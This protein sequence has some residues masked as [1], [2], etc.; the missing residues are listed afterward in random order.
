MNYIA[1]GTNSWL[2]IILTIITNPLLSFASENSTTTTVKPARGPTE[3]TSDVVSDDD[4]S[5]DSETNARHTAIVY[6]C[7]FSLLL[8]HMACVIIACMLCFRH[9]INNSGWFGNRNGTRDEEN[10]TG[11][12]AA[13]RDS[14]DEYLVFTKSV[15]KDLFLSFDSPKTSPY[16][17]EF[18]H[19]EHQSRQPIKVPF[20]GYDLPKFVETTGAKDSD[21]RISTCEDSRVTIN[22]SGI[23][24]SG[25]DNPIFNDDS[26]ENDLEPTQDSSGS[27][28]VNRTADDVL[29]RTRTELRRSESALP[30][31]KTL[32]KIRG[33]LT[34]R[35]KAV[36]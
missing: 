7:L 35:S 29:T 3:P 18:V 19:H 6:F 23:S 33:T 30:D 22:P 8:L 16:R 14:L 17:I 20:V 36:S 12:N 21:K 28:G 25:I 13:S 27:A 26:L 11:N 24:V 1:N 2:V 5:D 10:T 34:I 31:I 15:Q 32:E 9:A 4:V